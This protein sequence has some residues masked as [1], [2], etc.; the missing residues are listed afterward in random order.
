[1]SEVSEKIVK[2]TG[3][4]QRVIKLLFKFRF[5]SALGLAQ[6]IGISRPGIYPVFSHSV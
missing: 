5:V 1:M 2:L 4:Q 6:V 3:Q